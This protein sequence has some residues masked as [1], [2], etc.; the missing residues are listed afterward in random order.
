MLKLICVICI[1]LVTFSLCGQVSRKYEVATITERPT[2]PIHGSSDR[3]PMT[4]RRQ[5]KAACPGTLK[6]GCELVTRWLRLV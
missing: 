3:E 1:C 6:V 4:G 5:P 2:G